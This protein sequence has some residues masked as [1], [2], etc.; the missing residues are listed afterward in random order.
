MDGIIRIIQRWRRL[1]ARLK[2]ARAAWRGFRATRASVTS[3]R[4]RLTGLP[5]SRICHAYPRYIAQVSASYLLGEPVQVD[6]PEPGASALRAL[7][8]KASADSV[9]VELA[10]YQAIFGRAVSLCYEDRSAQPFV[11]SLNPRNAFV[12]YDDTVA[13]DPLFGV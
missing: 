10:L 7:L 5:N 2:W 8:L 12:V 3:C 11:C 13:G 6:G 1:S 9:D 4:A